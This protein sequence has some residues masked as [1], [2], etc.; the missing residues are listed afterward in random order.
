MR[1]KVL[2]RE[3]TMN[4]F[5]DNEGYRY[6]EEK[7]SKSSGKT[8][9]HFKWSKNNLYKAYNMRLL[10]SRKQKN[11]VIIS[12]D[13][14]LMNSTKVKIKFICPICGK[15]FEKK[16][17]HWI[18]QEDDKHFCSNCSVK[19]RAT[20]ATY[21]YQKLLKLY[22]NKGLRLLSPY[23]DY[24]KNGQS[25]ARLCCMD[26]EGYKYATNLNSLRSLKTLERKFVKSNPYSIENLQK[27]CDDNNIQLTI[28]RWV[29]KEKRNK[30]LVECDC[31]NCFETEPHKITSFIQ[32]RCSICSHKESS[33]EER[34]RKWLENN[35]IK[36]VKEYGFSDCKDKRILP[37]D[38]K[39]DFNDKIFLIEVDGSQHYYEQNWFNNISLE[40]RKRKDEIKNNFCKENGYVLIRLPFWTFNNN[41][42]IDKLNKTFFGQSDDLP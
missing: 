24:L 40:E 8:L 26:K 19:I 27:F 10:A 5:E 33:Y 9:E 34:V 7:Q 1:K 18:S 16:W 12:S 25:Y 22:E 17:C 3:K 35:K 13:E 14:D 2:L 11:C 4:Y 38:F 21:D 29:E 41:K 20:N 36:F 32:Y 28:I 6:K 31:G 37:F 30:I 23:E 15:I 42:Y 39:C